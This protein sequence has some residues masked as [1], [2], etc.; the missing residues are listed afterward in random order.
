MP[1]IKPLNQIQSAEYAEPLTAPNLVAIMAMKVA[2]AWV[3]PPKNQ[4]Q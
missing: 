3:D 2:Q 1:T 4:V